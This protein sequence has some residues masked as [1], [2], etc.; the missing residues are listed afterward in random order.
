M[1]NYNFEEGEVIVKEMT[2]LLVLDLVEK[3]LITESIT[4]HISYD[5]RFERRSSHGSVN[6]G[7]ATNSTRRIVTA[8]A[9][10]YLQIVDRSAGIRRI[11]IT[12]NNVQQTSYVQYDLF[13]D[14]VE[15]EKEIRMQNA[16]LK[17]HNRYGKNAML[18]GSNLLQCSTQR[19]R[20]RQIGGHWA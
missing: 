9:Q 6:L 4:L 17:V 20:N 12:C 5:H 18:R 16:M 8:A 15:T 10:L 2:D 11:N 19:E 1:R 13:S 14:P 3:N 7:T